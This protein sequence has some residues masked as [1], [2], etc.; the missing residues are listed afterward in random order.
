L[1]RHI[2]GLVVEVREVLASI[3]M[4]PRAGQTILAVRT[5]RNNRSETKQDKINNRKVHSAKLGPKMS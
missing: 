4:G 1:L 3:Y 5:K 2:L